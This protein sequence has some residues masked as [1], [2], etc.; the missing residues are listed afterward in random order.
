MHNKAKFYVTHIKARLM[1]INFGIVGIGCVKT[2]LIIYITHLQNVVYNLHN[3][4]EIYIVFSQ[5]TNLQITKKSY[6]KIYIIF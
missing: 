2:N 6:L 1:Y 5:N 3:K 4:R